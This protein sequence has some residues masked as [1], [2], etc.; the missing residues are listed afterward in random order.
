MNKEKR[1]AARRMLSRHHMQQKQKQKPESK[2]KQAKTENL[3]GHSCHSCLHYTEECT[4]YD[5]STIQY[6]EV[7]N[8]H[9]L[10][11]WPFTHTVC[12]KWAPR[13]KE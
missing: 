5:N 4:D 8:S 9:N 11:S 1:A 6:C 13:T 3:P 7:T 12:V 2:P 10:H